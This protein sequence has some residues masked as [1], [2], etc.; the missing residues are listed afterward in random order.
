MLR[1]L[2]ALLGLL[3]L[4]GQAV[5]VR[6]QSAVTAN[7]SLIDPQGFPTVAAL[8]DVFDAQGRY[9]TGLQPEDITILEDG[10]PLPVDGLSESTPPAQIVVAINPGPS[11]A[12]R[13]GEGIERFRHI[14]EVL[15][16]WALA[17]PPDT[18]DD[19]SLV[20][21]A[22]PIITH[23]DP[24]AWVV[25]LTSFQPDF[26]STTPNA[27][28]LII[29]LNTVNERITFPGVKRAILLVTPHMDEPNLDLTLNVLA[30][31]AQANGVRIFVWFVDSD[32]FFAS[33]SA[34][35]F[36]A[37]A[38]ATGGSFFTFSELETFPDPETYFS[39]L[40]NLYSL[41]YTSTVQSAGQHSL[42]ARVRTPVGQIT[43]SDQNFSVDIQP[44]NPILV[45]PPAQILRQ[46]PPEDPFNTE[47]L[48][49]SQQ[50][51]EIIVEFPD[52]HPRPLART[53][54]YVDGEI[55]AQN[56][57]EPFEVFEWD[58]SAYSESGQH[59]LV[60]EAV[61]SLGLSKT[62]MGLPVNI[63]V[64]HA[65]TGVQAMLTK[66]RSSIA[67]AAIVLAGGVLLSI[68]LYGRLRF[69]SRRERA[70]SRKRN[71]D[72]VTQPVEIPQAVSPSPRK[73]RR[74][75]PWARGDRLP[76]APAYLARLGKD[77]EPLTGNPIP[78]QEAEITFGTD[79]V[80]AM[81][82]LDHP[83]VAPLH[84]SLKRGEDGLYTLSDSGTVA[85]TWI[86]YEPVPVDG[87]ILKH[88]DVVHFG[89]LMYRFIL[90]VPPPEAEPTI[91][92]EA[93]SA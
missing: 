90:R 22:G 25:S 87:R 31:Q 12:V 65:P 24:S 62:S 73:K 45:M 77:G 88:G 80:Q 17:R 86:N 9:I 27:Q 56:D 21:L 53:S 64:I 5:V 16:G 3:L 81:L 33:E 79:P 46:A 49:P 69:K 55:V 13:D 50:S 67:I 44:P 20:T 63:T 29:A 91:T 72:P 85:G 2:L 42:S 39:P 14:V 84:A 35:A 19:L 93:P 75:L 82:V 8:L 54:L 41:S 70:E 68:L 7:L 60:V 59:E 57:T 61:D 1:R 23:A 74:S 32:N 26:R 11:L 48:L 15:G 30:E 10:V 52:G 58:M 28:V 78:L 47:V 92:P 89:Q 40:R 36:K 34:T 6:A 66:Y 37:L 18:P 43:S 4:A 76:E 51:L 38:L 71:T 83:S